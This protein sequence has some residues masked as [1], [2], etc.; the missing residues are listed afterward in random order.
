[1]KR[2]AVV[3]IVAVV[4]VATA[5]ATRPVA[6]RGAAWQAVPGTVVEGNVAKAKNGYRFL[7]ANRAANV[8]RTRFHQL[9]GTYICVNGTTGQE[10]HCYLEISPALITC[11][12]EA[13][14]NAQCALRP[15]LSQMN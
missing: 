11:T 6:A 2:F 9:V 3:L 13:G 4:A 14:G 5:T 15:K 1:M 10:A 7:K 12:G 8:E